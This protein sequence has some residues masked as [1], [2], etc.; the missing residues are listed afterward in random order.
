MNEW[1]KELD[2]MSITVRSITLLYTTFTD[3]QGHTQ[4][5]CQ[6]DTKDVVRDLAM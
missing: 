4:G 3:T 5:Q 2:N 1:W 6:G